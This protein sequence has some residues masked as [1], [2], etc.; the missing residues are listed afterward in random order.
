MCECM[1]M[2]AC[3]C[4][5]A[6]MY[7][8]RLVYIIVSDKQAKKK[9]RENVKHIVAQN[10]KQYIS[11]TLHPTV[12]E[13]GF[14][15]QSQTASQIYMHQYNSSTETVDSLSVLPVNMLS[16]TGSCTLG[17]CPV[18]ESQLLEQVFTLCICTFN[19]VLVNQITKCT[20]TD[21]HK[22]QN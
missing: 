3:M 4:M 7:A 11:P 15:V 5:C 22:R 17:C 16:C 21:N 19:F 13:T 18:N 14:S 20:D 9:K 10:N 6:C 1:C 12:C 8:C 2:H